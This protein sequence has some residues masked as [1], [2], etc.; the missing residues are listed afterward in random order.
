[1]SPSELS[2]E[3]G[4]GDS[5][6]FVENFSHYVQSSVLLIKFCVPVGLLDLTQRQE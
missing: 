6:M 3:T 1:M 5:F 4:S 2:S